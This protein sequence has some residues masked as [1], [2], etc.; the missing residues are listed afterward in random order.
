M[1]TPEFGFVVLDGPVAGTTVLVNGNPFEQ[2]DPGKFQLPVGQYE[3]RV[4]KEGKVISRQDV[5]VKALGVV[6]VTVKRN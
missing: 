2:Q 3:V 6:T 5:V 1:K 4:V